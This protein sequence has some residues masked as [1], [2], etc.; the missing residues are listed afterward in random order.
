MSISADRHRAFHLELLSVS[1]ITLTSHAGSTPQITQAVAKSADAQEPASAAQLASQAAVS[2]WKGQAPDAAST[3]AHTQDGTDRAGPA[4]L[5]AG[6]TTVAGCNTAPVQPDSRTLLEHG[7]TAYN[8]S[9]P[10]QL[11]GNLLQSST[12]HPFLKTVRRKQ[13]PP[14]PASELKKQACAWQAMICVKCATAL[15]QICYA[16]RLIHKT[17]AAVGSCSDACLQTAASQN[18]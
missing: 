8:A 15:C 16:R 12:S 10:A 6:Q 9:T 18:Q 13:L 7:P 11:G 17:Y 2:P 4:C 5:Q 14:R 1:M 3:E